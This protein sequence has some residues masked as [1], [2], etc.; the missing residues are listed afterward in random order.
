MYRTVK[1]VNELYRVL[2]TNPTVIPPP[3]K[4]YR[5]NNVLFHSKTY[6]AVQKACN[7][8][9]WKAWPAKSTVEIHSCVLL[10]PTEFMTKLSAAVQYITSRRQTKRNLLDNYNLF[11]V[12]GAGQSEIYWTWFNKMTSSRTCLI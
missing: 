2:K 11:I 6:R 9:L 12:L 1:K 5:L 7:E 10:L 4:P 3:Y 8:Q